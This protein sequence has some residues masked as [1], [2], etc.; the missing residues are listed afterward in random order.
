M[1]KS[2]S[3]SNGK[4]RD[5][6]AGRLVVGRAAFSKISEVEGI[7]PSRALRSDLQELNGATGEKRRKVLSGKYGK[8]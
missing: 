7:K 4:A 6:R 1:S 3:P 5:A 8:R 2:K